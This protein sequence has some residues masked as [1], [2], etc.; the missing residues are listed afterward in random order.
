[1]LLETLSSSLWDQRHALETLA[2]ELEVEK[3]MVAAGRV[4]WLGRSAAATEA[5][6]AD[7]MAADAR[8]VAAADE[9]AVAVGLEAGATIEQLAEAVPDAGGM[10]RAHREHLHRLAGEVDAL[11]EQTKI[12]LARNLAAVTDALA[13]LGVTPSYGPGPAG[14]H[15][16]TAQL[17]RSMLLDVSA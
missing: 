15:Q 6:L 5:A 13:L 9:L 11:V 12:L 17:G 3:L 10:L 2:Y 8:R 4:R 16:A 7:L 1:M 14:R